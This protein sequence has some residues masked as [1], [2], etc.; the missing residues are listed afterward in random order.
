MKE[1]LDI[2]EELALAWVNNNPI[3]VGWFKSYKKSEWAVASD[4]IEDALLRTSADDL[5]KL[6]ELAGLG[7]E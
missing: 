2:Y 3:V 5:A 6:F 4:E 1:K 7:K